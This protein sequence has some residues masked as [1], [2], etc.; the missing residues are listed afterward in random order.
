MARF[1]RATKLFRRLTDLGGAR[2]A[3]RI[4]EG[5][6]RA[7]TDEGSRRSADRFKNKIPSEGHGRATG[8]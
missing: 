7:Q 5:A 8:G 4:R 2:R 3:T 1:S 6:Y